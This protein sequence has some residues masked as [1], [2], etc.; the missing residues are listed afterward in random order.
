M[1]NWLM[2]GECPSPE[3]AEK[4]NENFVTCHFSLTECQI[5]L[6]SLFGWETKTSSGS[7]CSCGHSIRQRGGVILTEH[8]ILHQRRIF[9]TQKL[10]K[11]CRGKRIVFHL[12]AQIL[13]PAVV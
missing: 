7:D 10:K 13:D 4:K 3:S 5:C 9:G 12:L 11:T 2:L 1:A 8:D 6:S